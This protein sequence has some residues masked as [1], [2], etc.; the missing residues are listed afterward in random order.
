MITTE[1]RK[2][3]GK[4]VKAGVSPAKHAFKSSQPQVMRIA[5]S[6]NASCSGLKT[7]A[8]LAPMPWFHSQS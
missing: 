8:C 6:G 2:M 1:V 4:G 5:C 3:T 7:P